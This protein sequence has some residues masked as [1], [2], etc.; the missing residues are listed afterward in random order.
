MEVSSYMLYSSTHQFP[1]G[2]NKSG[3]FLGNKFG[4][5]CVAVG[6]HVD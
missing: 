5:Y 3:K 4:D 1:F 2:N 6:D